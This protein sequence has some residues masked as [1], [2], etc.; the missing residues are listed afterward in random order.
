MA[1][2]RIRYIRDDGTANASGG[3]VK[4]YAG[5]NPAVVTHSYGVECEERVA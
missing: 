5:S 1:A 4:H 3:A 2:R